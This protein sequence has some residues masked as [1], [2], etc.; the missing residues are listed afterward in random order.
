PT[1]CSTGVAPSADPLQ[2]PRPMRSLRA[3]PALLLALAAVSRPALAQEAECPVDI[4]QPSQ[5]TQAGISIGR[6][7][8]AG[9]GPDAQKALRDAMKTLSDEK[10]LASNPVGTGFL[11][12]QVY[13]LWLHQDG[14]Q[15]VMTNDAL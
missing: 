12:A 11:K 14:A 5:L 15:D 13:I 1:P 8:Q 7:A 3:F 6:A 2:P 10:K 9:S 4:Y